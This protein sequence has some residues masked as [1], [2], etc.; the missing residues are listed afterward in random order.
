MDKYKFARNNKTDLIHTHKF[1]NN[2]QCLKKNDHFVLNMVKYCIYAN[3]KKI[4]NN[5]VKIIRS[6]FPTVFTYLEVTLMIY[7]Y[8]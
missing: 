5:F 6:L 8:I 3:R 1:R 2:L 4:Y 7:T